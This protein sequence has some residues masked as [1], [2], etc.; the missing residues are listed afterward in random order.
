MAAAHQVPPKDVEWI[1]RL[2]REHQTIQQIAVITKRGTKTIR[3]VLDEAGVPPR[4]RTITGH[5]VN[6]SAGTKTLG[7][8]GLV[9]FTS[10]DHI[11]KYVARYGADRIEVRP[12]FANCQP[13]TTGETNA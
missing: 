11:A 7:K 2:Y 6:A 13:Y 12:K 9:G 3:K 1:L 5:L 8:I 4:H 10:P